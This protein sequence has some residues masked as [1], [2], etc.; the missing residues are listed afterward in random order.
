MQ[1]RTSATLVLAFTFLSNAAS[2][3]P[4]TEIRITG[5]VK[6][7]LTG[8]P[9]PRAIV[10][11]ETGAQL[12]AP[13]ETRNTTSGPSGEFHF[14]VP[15]NSVANNRARVTA[16]RPGYSPAKPAVVTFSKTGTDYS[17]ELTLSP[18][19]IVAGAVTDS[20]D[21][22]VLNAHVSVHRLEFVAGRRQW[23]SKDTPAAVDDKGRFRIAH[24]EPGLYRVAARPTPNEPASVPAFLTTLHP[25]ALD[26]ENSAAV[27]VN[28]GAETRADIRVRDQE[29]FTVS[30]KITTTAATSAGA[31]T[32][33]RRM[34]L[35]LTRG[36]WKP[37]LPVGRH[38][39]VVQDDATFE[40]R[41]VR[42]GIYTLSPEMLTL[43]VRTPGTQT[44]IKPVLFGTQSV[45][46]T[47]EDVRNLNVLFK[48]GLRVTGSIAFEETAAP[49]S[50]LSLLAVR[51]SALDSI[52]PSAYVRAAQDGAFDLPLVAPQR[53][54]ISVEGL[55]GSQYLKSVL[56]G[57]NNNSSDPNN[58]SFTSGEPVALHLIVSNKAATIA[59]RVE[60]PGSTVTEF[61]VTAVR[62]QD[63]DAGVIPMH[64][65]TTDPDGKFQITGLDPAEYEIL[66]WEGFTRDTLS[67]GEVYRR[68]STRAKRV[69][70]S[71]SATA[72]AD[73][74]VIRKEA[75]TASLLEIPEP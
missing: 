54:R 2:A 17:V 53:F 73:P 46:V 26:I 59:G 50:D 11:L 25:D 44:T 18:L 41:N 71:E 16:K 67:C 37:H 61:T 13:A 28:P 33:E 49:A 32:S 65:A 36:G 4:Q 39:A 55:T 51:L 20:N 56:Q 19:G 45:S 42:P 22:P 63:R 72:T 24:L 43:I 8:A 75:I 31:P 62:V 34:I 7:Q 29:T 74:A 23:L 35:T 15:L 52:G 14:S 70:L 12:G 30:G 58:L 60:N 66:A 48:P 27:T 68:F 3:Q 69:K 38:T 1:P 9:I 21:D 5:A 10:T 6:D 57:A 47:K 64:V 40:F